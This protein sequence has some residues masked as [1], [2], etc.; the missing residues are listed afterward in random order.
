MDMEWFGYGGR[1]VKPIHHPIRCIKGIFSFHVYC[2]VERGERDLIA[3]VV[4]TFGAYAMVH[5]KCI[6]YMNIFFVCVGMWVCGERCIHHPV[7]CIKGIFCFMYTAKSRGGRLLV[8][9]DDLL[10]MTGGGK[11]MIIVSM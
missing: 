10:L 11:R 6:I 7:R 3:L 8:W 5:T 2:E 1:D 9:F 4:R